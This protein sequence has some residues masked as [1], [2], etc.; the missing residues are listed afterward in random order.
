MDAD[1]DTKREVIT[2]MVKW[3]EFATFLDNY[4]L[5]IYAVLFIFG[6]TGNVILNIIITCNKDMRSVPN[7]YILNLAISDNIYLTGLFSTALPDSAK[8]LG[9]DIM[10]ILIPFCFRMSVILTMYSIAVLSFER[11][12]VTVYPLHVRFSS[13]P[14]WRATGATICGVWIVAAL[15]AIPSARNDYVC[16]FSLF[17]WFSYYKQRVAIFRLLVSCVLPL[18][19]IAFFYIMMSCH[20]LK[21]RYSL[22]EETQNARL[23]TR[24]NTAKVVLGLTVFLLF[25]YAPYHIFKTYL[26]FSINF[27]NSFNKIEESIEWDCLLISDQT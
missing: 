23:N 27:E 6:T 3:K 19:V 16:G 5:P 20:L 24:K 26:I 8:R 1:A 17:L 15:F 9:G 7:M 25:S 10:C 21:S 12:R 14:T 18:C 13:Q 2:E 22:S 4:K 11:Y